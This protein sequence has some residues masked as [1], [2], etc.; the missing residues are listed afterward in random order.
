MLCGIT[1][2]A[3]KTEKLSLSEVGGCDMVTRLDSAINSDPTTWGAFTLARFGLL[4]TVPLGTV[5]FTLAVD[6]T[7]LRTRCRF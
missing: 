2:W 3:K 1:E 6:D 7:V 4:G 5:G